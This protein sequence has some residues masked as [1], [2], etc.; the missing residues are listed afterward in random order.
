VKNWGLVVVFLVVVTGGGVEEVHDDA[1]EE[2]EGDSEAY[3]SVPLF[4]NLFEL[5]HEARSGFVGFVYVVIPDF[6]VFLEA[7]KPD[8]IHRYELSQEGENEFEK[9]HEVY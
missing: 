2:N 4:A 7:Q 3:L 9:S 1:L 8:G 5:A 6:T